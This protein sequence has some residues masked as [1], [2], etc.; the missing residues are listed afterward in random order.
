MNVCTQRR[1]VSQVLRRW[2]VEVEA[3]R[4]SCGGGAKRKSCTSC[5]DSAEF[6]TSNDLVRPT[7]HI[8]PK[9]LSATERQLVN[10]IGIHEMTNV[11]VRI[12]AASSEVGQVTNEAT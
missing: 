7:R 11:K 4:E 3:N 10:K 9:H 6:P 2:T 1:N 5:K 12:A 8:L